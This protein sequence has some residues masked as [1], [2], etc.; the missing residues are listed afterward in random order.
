MLVK[1]ETESSASVT[2]FGDIALS[3]LEMMGHSKTVPGAL[4]VE[5]VPEALRCLDEAINN[6]TESQADPDEDDDE[7]LD[8]TPVSLRHRALPLIKL[9]T[10]AVDSKSRVRWDETS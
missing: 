2:L 6:Q 1:F 10:A 3:L 5:D 9:L 8:E 4:Y 7:D